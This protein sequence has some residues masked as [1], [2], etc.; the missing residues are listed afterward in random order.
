[1]GVPA[2]FGWLA[3]HAKELILYDIYPFDGSADVLG[4][5]FN[6]R[7]HPSVKSRPGMTLDE[8]YTA[9]L[10]D[11]DLIV[12]F[13]NPKKVLYIAID[14]VAPRAKMEQQRARRYK[15]VK[16]RKLTDNIK[17]KH[18]V[19]VT[20]SD[21]DFNMISP[22]T[23]FMAKL[24]KK[25]NEHIALRKT[26][27][28]KHLKIIMS[29]AGVPGEGEHKLMKY[30]REEVPDEDKVA[31][32]GLD[33]DLIFLNMVN[34]HKNTVLVRESQQF[35][36]RRGKHKTEDAL[37]EEETF[38]YLSVDHLR[39]FLIRI[40]SPITSFGELE[41]IKIFN[42]FNFRVPHSLHTTHYTGTENNK[43]RF[44]LDYTFFCFMLGN[45]FLPHLPSLK[46]REGGLDV[47]VQAYKVVSW[48]LGQFL[49]NDDGVSVNEHFFTEMLSELAKKEDEFLMQYNDR[50]RA[51][52]MKFGYKLR[53]IKSPCDREIEDLTYVED[54]YDD[55]IQMGED[56]GWRIRYYAE[57]FRIPFRHKNEFR[58]RIK[59]ICFKY[60]EGMMW[61]L[62]YY[63]GK[64]PSW[65]WHYT[66]PESPSVKDLLDTFYD[67]HTNIND[68]VFEESSP[69]LPFVQLMCILPRDSAKLLPQ[70]IARLMTD[71]SSDFHYMY[72]LQFK[73]NYIGKKF[74]WE[75]HPSLPDIN[76]GKIT[77]A[78]EHLHD[79]TF[80]FNL[81]Y[82]KRN[83]FSKNKIY[84]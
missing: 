15:S 46:I 78:V 82:A 26:N 13:V 16:E 80:K 30:V 10:K 27:E 50:R 66:Y 69:V 84:K 1:M 40:L 33:S 58:K 65:D 39:D 29:D 76:I 18:G 7:I 72:P 19:E 36:D 79:T 44:V 25:L 68:I 52:I 56:N 2:F 57:H 81:T 48:K 38:T 54:K 11:L 37:H 53:G 34:Y 3:K 31:I 5:D 6:G 63:Q 47:V 64:Q 20:P 83:S 61:T 77:R 42:S 21:V 51:R 49:V 35:Q 24:A 4:L 41:G 55:R 14:G 17:R 67:H 59:P 8:M 73:V 71:R 75:C 45:D 28:W 60:L 23:D 62:R 32:Y 9:C 70:A 12:K 22:G 74:L 43:R